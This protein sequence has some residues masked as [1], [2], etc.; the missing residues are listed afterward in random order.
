MKYKV[1]DKIKILVIEIYDK[2]VGGPNTSAFHE[3]IM[4]ALLYRKKK[5]IIDLSN[6]KYI[7][8]VAIGILIRA[9]T[10]TRNAGS[11]LVLASLPLNVKWILAVTKLD[12]IFKIYDDVEEAIK[13]L[14]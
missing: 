8:S 2:F 14:T 12:S 6:V 3:E 9:L 10:T 13:H 5:I 1:K 4:E 11:D 7:N